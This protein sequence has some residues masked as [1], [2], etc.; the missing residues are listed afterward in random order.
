LQGAVRMGNLYLGEFIGTMILILL[1]DG[2]VANVV[3][4][5]SKGHGGGWIVITTG[6][7]MAVVFGV[8]AAIMAGSPY[9]F[10][11]PAVAIALVATGQVS[12]SVA[13]VIGC[14]IAEIL[15]A[16]VGAVLVFLAYYSH[17]AET[18]IQHLN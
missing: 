12:L 13:E 3:L 2:V 5:K 7:A 1:G 16:F 17:F 14:I 11:N 10:I 15:G 9:A 18:R 8:G 4:E 6:W